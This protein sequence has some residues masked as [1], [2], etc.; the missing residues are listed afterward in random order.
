ML[1]SNA[2]TLDSNKTT[3]V[4]GTDDTLTGGEM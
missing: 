1:T 4:R 3:D 2:V